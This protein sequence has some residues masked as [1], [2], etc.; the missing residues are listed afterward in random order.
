MVEAPVGDQEGTQEK[1]ERRLNLKLGKGTDTA[2]MFQ[3]E[4]TLQLSWL[5]H[6]LYLSSHYLSL[7]TPAW[8]A[9]L[10][11]SLGLVVG[12]GRKWGLHLGI[13]Q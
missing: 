7:G 9:S 6:K 4:R 13:R 3:K 8:K 5:F 12:T 11:E 10:Q 1:Q 2:L